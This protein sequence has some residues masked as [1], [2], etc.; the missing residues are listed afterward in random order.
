MSFFL[1]P[2]GTVSSWAGA[3]CHL[4][5]YECHTSVAIMSYEGT[6]PRYGMKIVFWRTKGE[7]LNF[8]ADYAE[9]KIEE[10]FYLIRVNI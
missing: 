2:T 8:V 3:G 4:N 6:P 1:L 7:R 9:L 5:G 10:S